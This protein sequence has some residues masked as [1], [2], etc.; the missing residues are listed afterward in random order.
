MKTT[1][2]GSFPKISED[3]AAPNLR[4]A[5]NRRDQGK[6]SDDDLQQVYDQTIERVIREQEQAGLDEIS[7][8]MIHWDDLADPIARAFGGMRRDA[9]LRFFDNNVYYRQP[10]IETQINWKPA[11]VA[12]FTTAHSLARRPLKAILPGP[13]TLARLS[14]DAYYKDQ[15]KLLSAL[16]G[17]LHDEALALQQAGATHI[18]IDEPSLCFAADQIAPARDALAVVTEGLSAMTSL[19]VYFGSIEEIAQDLFTFPVDRVGVDCASRQGNLDAVL[20]VDHHGKDVVLGLLDA[21]NT[22]LE[23][24]DD[25]LPILRRAAQ[26]IPPARLWISPSCGLEF[27]PHDRAIAKLRLMTETAARFKD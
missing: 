20:A 1:V 12:Y 25:L 11:T 26:H 23:S 24:A 22:R 6:I 15:R 13:L 2:V 14:R 3:P 7:D 18:Q 17:A 27:L 21:R 16:A 9:L 4:S 10:L 19:F 8:G 5:I